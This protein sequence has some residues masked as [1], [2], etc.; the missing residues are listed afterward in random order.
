MSDIVLTSLQ[1]CV[2]DAI[3]RPLFLEQLCNT[4]SDLD[5]MYGPFEFNDLADYPRHCVPWGRGAAR[6]CDRLQMKRVGRPVAEVWLEPPAAVQ[7]RPPTGFSQLPGSRTPP[8]LGALAPHR[9][10]QRFPA[11]A[12]AVGSL[13]LG[14]NTSPCSKCDRSAIPSPQ[15][16]FGAGGRVRAPK[17]RHGRSHHHTLQRA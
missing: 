9:P 4:S 16:S 8:P 13:N 6:S 10:P 7:P 5:L 14:G 17:E 1:D 2:A 11:P 12:G 15:G 3:A